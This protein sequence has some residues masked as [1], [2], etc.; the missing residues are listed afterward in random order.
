M[1]V[2]RARWLCPISAPPI[3]NGW[4][5]IDDGRIAGIGAGAVEAPDARVR[6]LGSVT[7]MPGLVNAHTH[8]ELSWLRGGVPPAASFHEWITQLFI[9]RGGR[10]EKRDDPSVVEPLRG[11]VREL[12]EAGVAAVGD[13]SNSLASVTPLADAGLRGVVFHEL[14]GF[15]LLHDRRVIDTRPLREQARARLRQGFGGQAQS[16]PTVKVSVAP[17]ACY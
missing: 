5:A 2:I 11:A 6:D 16:A 8:L 10:H 4:V 12:R 3:R 7:V 17:P 1:N 9:T 14:L 13:I 15:N